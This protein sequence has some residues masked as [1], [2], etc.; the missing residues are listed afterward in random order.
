MDKDLLRKIA[1]QLV[2]PGKGILATDATEGTV[3]KRMR[4]AGIE[5]TAELRRKFREILL[6]TPGMSEFISG[7]ILNDEII[8][9]KTGGD[10]SFQEIINSQGIKVGIKVDKKTHDMAN[11]PGEK[12]AEGLDGLRDRLKEYQ[13]MGVSFAKFRTVITIGNGN[14]TQTCI[15]SN[16]EVLARYA[17]L[18]QETNIVPVVEPEV[19]MD[20]DHS[21]QRCEEV[22]RAT[23]V[24]TFKFLEDHKVYLPGIILKPNMV[25]PGNKSNEI[26]SLED[27]VKATLQ[28]LKRTVP[29]EVPGIVFL[30]GGQDARDA[31]LRLNEMNKVKDLPWPLS[32]SFERAL[33]GPS[34]EIWAGDDSNWEK[35]QKEFYKRARLN[36]LARKGEYEKEMED[37][38]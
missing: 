24:S 23:L 6:T 14:P 15:D 30:S 19:I 21:L 2:A 29:G 37:G 13:A 3:D 12:I 7:V 17:A 28:T 8:R 1:K 26:P 20:G 31:T 36:S 22:T 4:A 18:C 25:L 5:P 9:Q 34:L 38:E 32:F 10:K 33:E 35:V 11:F 27:I 16:S